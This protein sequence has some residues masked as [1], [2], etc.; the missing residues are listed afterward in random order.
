MA[1]FSA[2]LRSPEFERVAQFDI[3]GSVAH[4]DQSIEIYIPTYTVNQARRTLRLE[5]PIIGDTFRGT[6]G[7]H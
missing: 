7:S 3:T 2:V 5:M 1:R 6:V 4:A